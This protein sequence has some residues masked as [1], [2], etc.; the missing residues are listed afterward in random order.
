MKIPTLKTERLIL[1]PITLDDVPAIQRRFNDW[2]IIK[3]LSSVVPWPYPD[4]GAETFIRNNVLPRVKNEG[5][6]VW[7]IVIQGQSDVIGL[8]D[9]GLTKG[10]H[11]DRGFWIAKKFQKKGYMSEAIGCVNDYLFFEIGLDKFTVVNAKSNIASRR[12]KEKTG[13]T[14]VGYGELEHH[15]G[16]KETEIWE[17]TRENW[18]KIRGRKL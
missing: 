5:H 11:G 2:E 8:I 17:V 14:F 12:V 1:R 3:N 10:A 16:E 18:A 9:F 7:G 15:N 13:A 4:D 6:M